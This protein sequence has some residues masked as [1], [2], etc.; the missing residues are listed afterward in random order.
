MTE[1]TEAPSG[2]NWI[3]LFLSIIQRA[4]L[5]GDYAYQGETFNLAP[6]LVR[7]YD[8]F[9]KI[10]NPKNDYERLLVS[11]EPRFKSVAKAEIYRR[12]T[13]WIA[14]GLRGYGGIK[15]RRV[16]VDGDRFLLPVLS[17]KSSV[18][19]DTSSIESKT[20][21]L[22]F[23]FIPDYEA[24]YLYL[25]KHL[26]VPKTHNPEEFKWSK[27]NQAYRTKLLQE[28]KSLI[29]ISCNA[30]LIIDTNAII[31]STGKFENLFKNLIEGCF[32]GYENDPR[33]A[34][35]RPGLRKKF[36]QLA[37]D[38]P[39]H[40]DKDFPHLTSDKAVKLF[41]QT[42]AKQNEW[43]GEYTPLYAAL[44]SH[45]SKPIQLADIIVGAIRTKTQKRKPLDPLTP[46]AFD[47]RKIA[48]YK[49]TYAKAFYWF[50]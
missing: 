46:I 34:K 42:L 31:S 23:C 19:I 25:E 47:K 4:Y 5:G 40:C 44:K 12:T 27:L 17:D 15:I 1:T 26:A 35:L 22:G 21:I 3:E 38:T 2:H 11:L 9:R 10:N 14:Q 39:V 24:A 20:T 36:F 28:F 43:Y 16:E 45:E 6:T 50:P 18:G 49:R 8:F 48:A 30:A 13:G 37:N 33:Y 41:V 32:S 29:S 7:P